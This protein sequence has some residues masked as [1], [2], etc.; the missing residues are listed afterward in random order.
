MPQTR[1]GYDWFRPGHIAATVNIKRALRL[2]V[3]EST[4][5]KQPRNP[6][7]KKA[8]DLTRQTII[9]LRPNVP[10]HA[11]IDEEKET[12]RLFVAHRGF[13]EE[14]TVSTEEIADRFDRCDPDVDYRKWGNNRSVDT[15][16]EV[17][18]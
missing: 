7:A 13:I 16:V 14:V 3:T 1:Y 15:K 6:L 2:T 11:L 12:M 10:Y 8:T 4:H 5:Y 9:E 18:K 17:I